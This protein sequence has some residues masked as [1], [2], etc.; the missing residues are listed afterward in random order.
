M[1]SITDKTPP[2]LTLEAQHVVTQTI[3]RQATTLTTT[4]TLAPANTPRP[5][6]PIYGAQQGLSSLQLGAILGSV[7]VAAVVIL[8]AGICWTHR[9][10]AR[11]VPVA[12]YSYHY[13]G[14]TYTY[15]TPSSDSVPSKRP[16]YPPPVADFIPGC[17]RYPT[18]KAL[19]IKNPRDPR[20]LRRVYV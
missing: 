1:T 7:A 9:R 14:D 8:A 19:P 15:Y 11:A 6:A 13:D 10:R 2:L 17:D 4:I 12:E 3:T 16:R 18:Y 20:N 5:D